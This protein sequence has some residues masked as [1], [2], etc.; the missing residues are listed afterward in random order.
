[1]RVNK[2]SRNRLLLVSFLNRSLPRSNKKKTKIGKQVKKVQRN[3]LKIDFFFNFSYYVVMQKKPYT[4]HFHLE[5][6]RDKNK[7]CHYSNALNING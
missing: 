5:E 3:E 4:V 1:M 7:C 2:L 6:G